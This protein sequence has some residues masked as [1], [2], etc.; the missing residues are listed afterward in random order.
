LLFNVF[1]LYFYF[2]GHTFDWCSRNWEDTTS[3]G[4][5]VWRAHHLVILLITAAIAF[6]RAYHY[7]IANCFAIAANDALG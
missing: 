1:L 6:S 5:L 2:A 3:K 4:E 7:E